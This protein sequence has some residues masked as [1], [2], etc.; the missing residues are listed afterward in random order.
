MA[1][2][3]ARTG[4]GSSCSCWVRVTAAW[5]ASSARRRRRRGPGC[6]PSPIGA[7]SSSQPSHQHRCTSACRSSPMRL[8]TLSKA[9]NVGRGRLPSTVLSIVNDASARTLCARSLRYDPKTR[10]SPIDALGCEWILA[11]RRHPLKPGEL[12]LQETKPVLPSS[13]F[14]GLR[15][16]RTLGFTAAIDATVPTGRRT[17]AFKNEHANSCATVEGLARAN[18][19]RN[20]VVTAEQ[21]WTKCDRR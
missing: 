19:L 6:Q 10:P 12:L 17:I 1:A 20:G 2:Q 14:A 9:G 8:S 7:R 11:G 18:A 21:S 16:R 13:D 4:D 3:C 5:S 15:L